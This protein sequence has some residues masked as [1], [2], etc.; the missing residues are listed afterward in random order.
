[1]HSIIVLLPLH[2]FVSAQVLDDH[3]SESF[4]KSVCVVVAHKDHMA[5][6]LVSGAGFINQPRINSVPA[7]RF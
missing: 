2:V 6:A 1:M 4:V 5:Q 3:E 7:L